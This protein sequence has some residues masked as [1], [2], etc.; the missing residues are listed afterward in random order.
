MPMRWELDLE[1]I[2]RNY[3]NP[4]DDRVFP[5]KVFGIGWDINGHALLRRFGALQNGGNGNSVKQAVETASNSAKQAV[6]SAGKTVE[7]TVDR[8]RRETRLDRED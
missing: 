6:E 3:W 5:P 2:M 7:D 1:K 8:V 4:D